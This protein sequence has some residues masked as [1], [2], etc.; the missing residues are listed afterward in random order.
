[1]LHP[2]VSLGRDPLRICLIVP[3]DLTPEAGGVKQHAVHLMAGLERRGD[4][5]TL[6]GPASA[7]LAAPNTRGFA[8]VVSIRGNGSHNRMGLLCSPFAL[9][10]FFAQNPFDIL[11]MH[12]PEVP[13]LTYW[14]SWMQ[15]RVPKVA[16][17]HAFAEH[18]PRRVQFIRRAVGSL[19]Y[20][21]FQAGI[22]VSPG[23]RDLAEQGFGR[24]LTIIPNGVDHRLFAPG[25]TIPDDAAASC[26]AGAQVP[27]RLLFV[28][29][30]DHPRKGA[31]VLFEALAQLKARNVAVSV[32]VVGRAPGPLPNGVHH[33]SNVST[34]K[35]AALYRSCD[36]LVAPATGQESFGIIL[37]EAMASGK[38]IIASNIDGYR[39]VVGGEAE[40]GALLVPPNEAQAL[41]AA[42]AQLQAMP[43][44]KRQEMGARNLRRITPY[45]WDTVVEAV[46]EVYVGS[47]ARARH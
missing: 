1:M 39:R 25:P 8:G 45:T 6:I 10:R 41:A 2:P 26:S 5:V 40:G 29:G 3:Y 46:R 27:L 9:K 11:H 18:P 42:I 43:A 7:P 19:L 12:E 30:V 21:G 34:Q 20:R 13:A 23:A 37:L 36:A 24:P 14:A 15:R 22:A 4:R 33:H 31:A 17:F 47:I 35:L 28:G 16:T 38:P 32:D 44:A